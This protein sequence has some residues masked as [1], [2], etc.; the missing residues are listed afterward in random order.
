MISRKECIFINDIF[1][2]SKVKQD[3]N[4]MYDS[5]FYME[6]QV[7]APYSDF[8]VKRMN[9]IEVMV[10]L[11]LTVL[12]FWCSQTVLTL[13]LKQAGTKLQQHLLCVAFLM[14]YAMRAASH[15]WLPM[16]SSGNFYG[17]KGNMMQ[18]I[19]SVISQTWTQAFISSSTQSL[20]V[21][22]RKLYFT[23]LAQWYSFFGRWLC[24]PP[25]CLR[26]G[27]HQRK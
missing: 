11:Q 12:C 1:Q 27:R 21:I 22:L 8:T 2:S 5:F 9:R 7:H 20:W 25:A 3:Q 15:Q 10:A 14:S 4:F 13:F 16:A 24:K 6:V 26:P 18:P 23:P 19:S 17:Q